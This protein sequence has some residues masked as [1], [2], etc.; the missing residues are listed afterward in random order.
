M[1]RSTIYRHWPERSELLLEAI[2]KHLPPMVTEET[3]DLRTDL[4]A[5]LSELA[6]LL[7]TEPTGTV[8]AS[9]IVEARRDPELSSMHR[10]FTKMRRS[11]AIG[12][13]RRAIESGELP[14]DTD[15]KTMADDLAAPIFYK[16]LV[17]RQPIDESWVQAHVDRW[18]GLHRRS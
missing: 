7:S 10:K 11:A 1:A 6:R 5:K 14:E 4:T 3:G 16:A 8:V 9:F 13:I 12:V 2:G 17:L 15:P 18:I